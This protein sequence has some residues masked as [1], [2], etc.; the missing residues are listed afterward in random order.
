MQRVEVSKHALKRAKERGI[1]EEWAMEIIHKPEE[2]VGIKF[3]RTASYKRFGD[4][5]AVVIYEERID[6]I[7]GVTILKVDTERLGRYGF[8]GI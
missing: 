2:T 6:K 4:D 8:G 7:V 3:G 5:Y 1:P